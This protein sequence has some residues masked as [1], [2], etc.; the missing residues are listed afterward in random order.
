MVVVVMGRSNCAKGAFPSGDLPKGVEGV[1]DRLGFRRVDHREL[2]AAVV[3]QVS[4]VVLEARNNRDVQAR[5]AG[6]RGRRGGG[7]RW[8]GGRSGA[9]S[10]SGAVDATP[11][12]VIREGGNRSTHSSTFQYAPAVRNRASQERSRPKPSG[13]LI[14]APTTSIS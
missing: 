1:E 12:R 2:S 13:R 9:V 3:E 7:G 5:Q 4:V 10:S 11:R 6:G 14:T 8:R